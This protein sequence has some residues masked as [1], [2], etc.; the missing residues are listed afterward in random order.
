L[1]NLDPQSVYDELVPLFQAAKRRRQLIMV[2]HNANPV[3]NTDADQI[4]VA[5]VG[6]ASAGG[7]P[8]IRYESGGLD[9]KPIRMSCATSSNAASWPSGSRAA[10]PESVEALTPS[11][12][13]VVLTLQLRNS[14]GAYM[15]VAASVLVVSTTVLGSACANVYSVERSE[16]R[17]SQ[18]IP[19]G[20]LPPPGSCRVWYDG[21]PAGQQPPPTSCREAERVTARQHGGRVIYAQSP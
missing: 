13:R 17:T 5:K 21:R 12:S 15:R 1:E 16:H 3:I 20:H 2:T 18:G 14:K 19:A 7:L 10:S 6:T 8:P 9:E 4:I 11:S